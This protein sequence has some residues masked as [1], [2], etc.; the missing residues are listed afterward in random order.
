MR[1][2]K[3]CER[4]S[5]SATPTPRRRRR[6]RRLEGEQHDD[7]APVIALHAQIRDE[8]PP[9]GH[10]QQ[11][12]VER[13]Q[14]A[15]HHADRREQRGRL[16]VRLDRLASSRSSSS[17]ASTLRRP[18]ASVRSSRRDAAVLAAAR[19]DQDLRDAPAQPGQALRAREQR[20]RD[21]AR[22][23]HAEQRA[24]STAADGDRVRRA[25]GEHRDLPPGSTPTVAGDAL[26]QYQPAGEAESSRD[27]ARAC[28]SRPDVPRPR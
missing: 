25:E 11:H 14:E 21:R 1:C 10:R 9:L 16:V 19:L 17:A 7:L 28:R 27:R 23:Q 20:H 3:M 13:Q 4:T 24:F 12:R 18:A 22:G 2:R 8:P 15:D 5:P 26:G 6:E